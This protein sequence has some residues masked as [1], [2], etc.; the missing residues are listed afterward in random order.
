MLISHA[1]QANI[2]IQSDFTAQSRI[3]NRSDWI[4]AGYLLYGSRVP[5]IVDNLL[6]F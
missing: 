6:I 4:N 1:A 2:L 5:I 3:E